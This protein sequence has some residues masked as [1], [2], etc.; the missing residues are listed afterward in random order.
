MSS[1]TLREYLS[2]RQSVCLLTSGLH[3]YIDVATLSLQLLL[4]CL[5]VWE[6][7]PPAGG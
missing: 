2:V 4:G 5:T 1:T 7:T 3:V 6:V